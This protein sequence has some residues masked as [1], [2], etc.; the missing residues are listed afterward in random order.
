ME[1]NFAAGNKIAYEGKVY[2]IKQG[3]D[4]C[5]VLL[6]DPASGSTVVAKICNIKPIEEAFNNNQHQEL[7]LNS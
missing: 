6:E 4:L 5:H 3:L 2:S 7:T 1:L